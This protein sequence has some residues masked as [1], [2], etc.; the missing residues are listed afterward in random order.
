MTK[1]A[2]ELTNSVS[3]Q[4]KASW[5]ATKIVLLRYFIW[6][7]LTFLL[8]LLPIMII[9]YSFTASIPWLFVVALLALGY[10]MIIQANSST[11]II[12]DSPEK[13]FEFQDLFLFA[14]EK[15]KPTF[16]ATLVCLSLFG[17]FFFFIIPGIIIFTF[18]SFALFEILVHNTPPIEA[19][20][21]SI[22]LWQTHVSYL[23]KHLVFIIILQ[24]L[25]SIPFEAADNYFQQM[26]SRDLDQFQ[27]MSELASGL[28]SVVLTAFTTRYFY[29]LYLTVNQSAVE[30]SKPR[31]TLIVIITVLGWLLGG[32]FITGLM[33]LMQQFS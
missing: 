15:F 12:I 28:I 24:I 29:D 3:A 1:T 20:K 6:Q 16:I 25:V 17:S 13:K 32:V 30:L 8:M 5:A 27:A 10:V 4:A 33:A 22:S 2:T 7:C 21:K 19:I 14:Q 23:W 11:K 31:I 18:I 26:N 9:M